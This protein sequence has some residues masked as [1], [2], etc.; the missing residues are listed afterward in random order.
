MRYEVK[1][2]NSAEW[3]C[4]TTESLADE[5]ASGR[6]RGQW[7]IKTE[8]DSKTYSVEELC[9]LQA[10]TAAKRQSDQAS[11][12]AARRGTKDSESA[13]PTRLFYF[14]SFYLIA[15]FLW[16]ALTTAY[17]FHSRNFV[18]LSIGLDALCV[19][20]LIG[21]R[22]KVMRTGS[23]HRPTW[24]TR[25]LLFVLALIAGL[26]LLAIR[27]DSNSAWWTGHLRFDWR[28]RR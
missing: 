11:A 24:A 1:R 5:L 12:S 28:G 20:G 21:L 18:Y 22:I 14:L 25:K 26:G 23:A 17:E 10:S 15:T 6:L 7:R 4:F 13:A 9:D 27:L 19:I 2:P 8:W 3:E 16:R